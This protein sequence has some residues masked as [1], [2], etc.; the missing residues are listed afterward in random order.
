[1]WVFARLRCDI[2]YRSRA[3]LIAS[4][5][6]WGGRFMADGFART[7]YDEVGIGMA[8]ARLE[9]EVG[10]QRDGADSVISRLCGK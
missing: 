7:L 9:L 8:G 3:D 4:V 6:I 10:P 2:S 1:M 5:L